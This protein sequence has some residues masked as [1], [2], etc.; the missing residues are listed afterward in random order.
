MKRQAMFSALAM[1]FLTQTVNAYGCSD[2]SSV[3][4]RR[5]PLH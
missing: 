3:R 5:T 4:Y 1:L 2:S